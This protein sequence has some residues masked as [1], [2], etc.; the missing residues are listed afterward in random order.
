MT[1]GSIALGSLCQKKIG[2]NMPR[3]TKHLK[4]TEEHMMEVIKYYIYASQPVHVLTAKKF[5]ISE[6]Q[7][8]YLVHTKGREIF[9]KLKAESGRR[10]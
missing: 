2:N 1:N 5:N 3:N 8:A 10:I 7:V 4:H 9:K 6:A